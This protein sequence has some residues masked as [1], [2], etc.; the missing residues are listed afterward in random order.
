M[1]R[2]SINGEDI[3]HMR[4]AK[5]LDLT[6]LLWFHPPNG[7]FRRKTEAIRFK[8]MGV[9]PGVPDIL[10]V[11]PFDTDERW[12]PGL[13]VEL[14]TKSGV[15]TKSQKYWR[16]RLKSEGWKH[17]VCRSL[18]DVIGVVEDCYGMRVKVKSRRRE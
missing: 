4:V 3:L 14:K 18:D 2:R 9:K 11:C 12:Y 1:S 7:G 10:I 5:Y 17:S 15:M 6:G 8:K 13:A 16:D